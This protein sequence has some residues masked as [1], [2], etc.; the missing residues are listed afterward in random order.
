MDSWVDW[1]AREFS[2][3][4]WDEPSFGSVEEAD[5]EEPAEEQAIPSPPPMPQRWSRVHYRP[6]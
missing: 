1:T 6:R 2:A 5:C 3:Y 4:Y